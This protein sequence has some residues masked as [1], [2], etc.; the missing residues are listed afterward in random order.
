MRVCTLPGEAFVHQL[1]EGTTVT[2][3]TTQHHRRVSIT[4]AVGA[5]VVLLM[6]GVGIYGLVRG[7]TA[8]TPPPSAASSV[9]SPSVPS[10]SP[11]SS[12]SPTTRLATIPA[13]AS[14]ETF[15]RAVAVAL[16]TWDTTSGLGLS[17]YA[18]VLADAADPREADAL[19]SDVRAYL[20]GP[21]VWARLTT[22]QTRQWLTIDSVA[23]PQAW[24]TARVQ[25]APGQLPAGAVASTITGVRHRAGIWGTSPVA[26][27]HPV[28][29]TVFATCPPARP[30][31]AAG[32]CRLVR[33]SGPDHPLH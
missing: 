19:A 30:G 23:V 8:T 7:P 24:V 13:T 18:Q 33:L 4:G 27:A 21:D 16:F 17:G 14:P 11:A 2:D 22:Y 26:T 28:A 12:V 15:A 10:P 9:A 1:R 29:F 25:A 31:Y 20:P 5:A 3:P 32:A 6:T